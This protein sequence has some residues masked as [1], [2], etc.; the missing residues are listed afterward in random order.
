MEQTVYN[1][2]KGRLETI[3]IEFTDEN[4]TWFDDH[5]KMEQI[6]MVTDFEAGLV[7]GGYNYNYPILV[8]DI[9]RSDI[10]DDIKKVLDLQKRYTETRETI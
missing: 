2:Q 1:P 7:I 8:Y 10:N 9:S 3:N 4:T 6:Y 5:E